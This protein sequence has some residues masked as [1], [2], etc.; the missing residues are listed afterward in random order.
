LKGKILIVDDEE[1]TRETLREILSDVGYEVE[2][3]SSGYKAVE[4]IKTGRFDAVIVDIKMPGVD[5]LKVLEV[6]KEVDPEIEVIMITGYASLPSSIEALRK[7]A[8]NYLLKPLD[9]EE[10]KVSLHKALER[11]FLVRENKRLL[12]ELKT[13]NETLRAAKLQAERWAHAI[14][15]I[16]K[17]NEALLPLHDF[18]EIADAASISLVNVID[19]TICLFFLKL[20]KGG[21][22]WIGVLKQV[23]KEDIEG[24]ITHLLQKIEELFKSKLKKEELEITIHKFSGIEWK[25]E[26]REMKA[27]FTHPLIHEGRNIGMLGLMSFEREEFNE[28]DIKMAYAVASQVAQAI[29]RHKTSLVRS[30]KI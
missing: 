3:A 12:E 7:G 25:E 30:N 19:F 5:G 1:G 4:E 29:E 8:A 16:Y 21:K 9:I 22:L 27:V 14:N 26:K 15:V 11:Q 23:S 20:R 17:L 2:V 28:V 10:L 13:S 18:K 6:A 24:A